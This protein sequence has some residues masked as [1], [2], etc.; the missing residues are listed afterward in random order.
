[1]NLLSSDW[2]RTLALPL[3]PYRP[4]L[5]DIASGN[6]ELLRACALS[7]RAKLL[8]KNSREFV[9]LLPLL[10]WEADC[11]VGHVTENADEHLR[12]M[13]DR[14]PRQGE[15]MLIA[16]E[17]ELQELVFQDSE[18]C[19]HVWAHLLIADDWGVIWFAHGHTTGPH[20][21]GYAPTLRSVAEWCDHLA[22]QRDK[23]RGGPQPA[24]YLCAENTVELW[25]MALTE[26]QRRNLPTSDLRPQ[27]SDFNL[28]LEQGRI[29]TH[30]SAFATQSGTVSP[31]QT[32]QL[33]ALTGR[34]PMQLLVTR[35][36][37]QELQA[38]IFGST[39]RVCPELQRVVREALSGFDALRAP[40]FPLSDIQRIAFLDEFDDI[41]CCDNLPSTLDSR[42]STLF[43]AGQRYALRSCVIHVQRTGQRVNLT[44]DYDAVQW[45]GQER[46]FFIRDDAGVEHCF[47][48]AHLL[49]PQVKVFVLKPDASVA[50]GKRPKASQLQELNREFTLPQLAEHFIVP[51]VPDIATLFPEQFAA[52][53]KLIEEIEAIVN[54]A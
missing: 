20:A 1:M 46:A 43:R 36:S 27:T 6:L 17:H 40:I 10:Q 29:A 8:A 31:K 12:M 51:A 41:L 19:Q 54:A 18:L 33:H 11:F 23:L 15:G 53:L 25:Q 45:H 14:C 24:D 3:S 2:Y 21:D 39:W 35:E 7:K 30:I 42:L 28:W 37:R 49:H 44:G 34:Q 4:V 16:P 5:V 32:A 22:R 26:W 52:N 50:E 13:L 47:L 38:V 48:A 9:D